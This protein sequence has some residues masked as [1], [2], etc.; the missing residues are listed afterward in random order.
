MNFKDSFQRFASKRSN[1]IVVISIFFI[2]AIIILLTTY[3]K[4]AEK[5]VNPNIFINGKSVG[6]VEKENLR[7]KI[8][9]ELIGEYK[10]KVIT[11]NAAEETIEFKFSDIDVT[12]NIDKITDEVI[13]LS[14]GNVFLG[15]FGAGDSKKRH[16]LDLY[17]S[18]DS[19]KLE[20]F[21]EELYK[22]TYVELKNF[23][24][25]VFESYVEVS[26]GNP[27]KKIDKE[28]IVNSVE[29]LIS[30][31]TGSKITVQ[32]KEFHPDKFDIDELYTLMKSE[33]QDATLNVP[34]G[35]NYIVKE[36]VPG[37]DFDKNNL[38]DFIAE[39]E[40]DRN[41]KK[42]IPIIFLKPE[43][44]TDL[45]IVN[46]FKDKLS[47]FS[48]K[49]NV[50]NE[51][52]ASNIVLASSS[53][54]GFIVPAGKT[55]SFNESTGKRT[56]EK[57]YKEAPI[58]L[59]GE[60]STG[61]A[62]GICQISTT[63][64]NAVL[65]NPILEI[66]DRRNHTFTVPYVGPGLDATVSYGVQDY[67]FK[68]TSKYPIK[69][70]ISASGGTLKTE[71]IGTKYYNSKVEIKV[72]QLKETE[73]ITEYKDDPELNEG[74]EKVIQDPHNGGEFITY[75]IIKEGDTSKEVKFKSVYKPMNEIISRGTK[76]AS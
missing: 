25:E 38:A 49:F 34:N 17:Y 19:K 75:R 63:L 24:I 16:Y 9:D 50:N 31:V 60:L 33:P 64:H 13:D 15:L 27:E 54:N 39:L 67:K 62:G 41:V 55:F 36:H 8:K 52:R 20:Q 43:I 65:L 68:N 42:K 35:K 1:V 37:M 2:I 46:M 44:T 32:M 29:K 73:Y 6:D 69:V 47:S 51:N 26:Y 14:N 70:M 59:N 48:T 3:S 40:N 58:Y 57:G 45:L 23:N 71:I 56:L 22:A 11:L 7:D 61:L 21:I 53:I 10:N 28:E 74:I 4:S 30:V 72:E 76:K 5:K 18:Y 66:T 12:Y